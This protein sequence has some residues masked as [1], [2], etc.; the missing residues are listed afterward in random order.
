MVYTLLRDNISKQ[1]K[2]KQCNLRKRRKINDEL[3]KSLIKILITNP[4]NKTQYPL[5]G[6]GQISDLED[7]WGYC[8]VTYILVSS[9]RAV[10]QL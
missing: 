3:V 7:P 9:R 2:F 1:K 5:Y 4:F 10:V 8:P 6:G